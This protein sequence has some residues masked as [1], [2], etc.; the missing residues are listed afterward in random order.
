MK[1]WHFLTKDK[2]LQYGDNREVRLGE[3]LTV[4]PAELNPC[5]YGL[6]ASVRALDA[7]KYLSWSDA[8]ICYVELGGKIIEGGDK[9][10]ASERT[11]VA[12]RKADEVLHHFACRVALDCL[13][14]FEIRYPNDKRPREAI[15]TKLKWFEGLATKDELDVAGAAARA[16]ARAAA[17]AAARAAAEAAAWAAEAVAGA[18]ARAAARAAA[19]AA[20]WA[21][22]AVAGAAARAK[23]NTWL[24]EMFK[25]ALGI[26]EGCDVQ[27]I[28]L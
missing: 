2:M 12:W 28:P 21:A 7:L 13:H 16:A 9:H 25:G 6:H 23:Y 18:A 22:E 24:E 10:V 4:D 3:T 26:K 5:N 11:V 19:W 1:A 14:H 15:D 27:A 17:G 20:A 8:V